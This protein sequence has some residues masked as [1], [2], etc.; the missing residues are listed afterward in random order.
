MEIEITSLTGLLHEYCIALT[1]IGGF[2]YYVPKIQND[3]ANQGT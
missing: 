2:D 3:H 1:D